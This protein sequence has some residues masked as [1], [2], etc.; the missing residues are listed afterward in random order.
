MVE[1]KVVFY[2]GNSEYINNIAHK[3]GQLL[4]NTESKRISLDADEQRLE[5]GGTDQQA[6]NRI[7]QIELELMGVS[8][9]LDSVNGEVI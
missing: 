1:S 2:K 6:R 9:A 7:E 8:D 4:F 5:I 3:D